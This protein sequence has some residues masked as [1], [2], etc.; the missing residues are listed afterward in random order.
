M[1]GLGGLDLFILVLL[2]L[3]AW[4]GYRTGAIQQVAGLVGLVLAFLVGARFMTPIGE[5]VV[6]SLGL[7]ERI[8]PLVGFIVAFGVVLI[9]VSLALRGV[10]SFLQT[11]KLG[12]LDTL[13]GLLVGAFTAAL[14]V[15]I[16]LM[17]TEFATL[18]GQDDP[19]IIGRDTREASML[20][21]AVRAIGPDTWSVVQDV[22]PNVYQALDQALGSLGGA[23]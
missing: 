19:L 16:L 20:Y 17:V 10:R 15:S 12:A 1:D 3:G 5:G 13:G 18:P 4:R 23:D 21:P 22:F 14:G 6:D 2:A 11:I 9:G 7:S 8:A